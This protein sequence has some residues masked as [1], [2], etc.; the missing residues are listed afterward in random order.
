M[1][2]FG[3]LI[4]YEY[5]V[6]CK[7][8]EVACKMEHG[9]PQDEYGICVQQAKESDPNGKIYFIPFP[10]DN[11]NMCGKRRAK[12]KKTS[13]EKHCWTGAIKFGRIE[14]LTECLKDKSKTVLWVPH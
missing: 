6:G 8:C 11:C 2:K 14:E 1:P 5:C 9:R 7:S 13:C 4:D 10:T 3:L 12:G